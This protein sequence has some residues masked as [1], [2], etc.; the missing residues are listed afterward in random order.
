MDIRFVNKLIW[1]LIFKVDWER[2]TRL[3]MQVVRRT[4]ISMVM[5]PAVPF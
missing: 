3:V 5:Q 4:A 2:N 1:Q